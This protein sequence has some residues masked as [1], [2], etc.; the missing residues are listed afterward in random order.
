MCISVI[1]ISLNHR[2]YMCLHSSTNPSLS[3]CLSLSTYQ[4]LYKK[5]GKYIYM[6]TYVICRWKAFFK[7]SIVQ[8]NDHCVMLAAYHTYSMLCD[9]GLLGVPGVVRYCVLFTTRR[10]VHVHCCMSDF[11][12][13]IYIR[14]LLKAMLYTC[15]YFTVK[16]QI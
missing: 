16:P 1:E 15:F 7:D 14:T 5:I 13:H 11:C 6:F 12:F 8:K 2:A 4:I 9:F 3:V 10:C